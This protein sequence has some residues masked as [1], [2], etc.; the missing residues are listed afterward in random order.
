MRVAA[1][2]RTRWLRDSIE[3]LA[4]GGHTIC[5]IGSGTE[6]P[7]SCVS[8]DTFRALADRVECPYFQAN[9]FGPREEAILQDA[10]SDIGISVNWP[11]L[12]S[13]R[14]QGLFDHGVLNAHA[15]DL[16][17]FRGNAC[18]NWAILSGERHVTISI[19]QMV[20]ALDAGPVYA[21]SDIPV[22]ETTYV[23]EIYEA[24]DERI[25]RMF[26]DV[27]NQLEAGTARSHAQPEAPELSLRCFPRIPS[28]SRIDW[29]ASAEEIV[30][31]VRASA[32]PFSGAYTHIG[33]ERLTVW[34][35]EPSRLP[36]P[37]LGTP[38]QVV[39][40]STDSGEVTV[41]A[42]SGTVVLQEVSSET[43][44][45]TRP[46]DTIRSLRT[47]LGIDAETQILALNAEIDRLRE[48]LADQE[49]SL[50]SP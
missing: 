21:K 38:G 32:A 18:P 34:K 5:A 12:V 10:R 14:T 41:L 26:L 33:L 37:C 29:S 24:L 43:S 39:A 25:P 22:D 31:I 44:S 7:E 46:A 40:R 8:H 45:K 49:R 20:D 36:Y 1:F 16:P 11:T 4:E 3:A 50:G 47:R 6:S 30:A 28:D 35:A 13:T 27:V 48:Q 2:G 9:R 19:H 17:R 42:G 23:T 15:G